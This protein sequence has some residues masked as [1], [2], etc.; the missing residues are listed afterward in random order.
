MGMVEAS[1]EEE[2]K[3]LNLKLVEQQSM[4]ALN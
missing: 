4:I 2:G 3:V 1:L